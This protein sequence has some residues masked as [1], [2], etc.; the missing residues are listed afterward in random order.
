M[1]LFKVIIEIG[2]GNPITKS[3]ALSDKYRKK[4]ELISVINY[5]TLRGKEEATEVVKDELAYLHEHPSV[6]TRYDTDT[7]NV[8]TH[9]AKVV[10]VREL[11]QS[12]NH[13]D[14]L[15]VLS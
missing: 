13:S 7:H 8:Y 1:Q 10:E 6:V 3:P 5:V 15:F 4:V 12:R 11:S 2:V 9:G 14:N